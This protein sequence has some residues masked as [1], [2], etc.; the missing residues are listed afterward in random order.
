MSDRLAYR[1]AYAAM[2]LALAAACTPGEADPIPAPAAQ[3]D[4][5]AP[6]PDAAPPVANTSET[7]AS[8]PASELPAPAEPAA[9]PAAAAADLSPAPPAPTAETAPV[10][11]ALGAAAWARTCAMCHGP[12]GKGTQMAKAI[13]TRSIEVVKNKVTKG[14][15]NP[16]DK[17]PP[18]GAALSA[19]EL[20]AV[21]H[22]VAGGFKAQ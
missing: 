19:E 3:S 8:S 12:D 16:G 22:F 11:L 18:L 4:I 17:M 20:E 6:T 10:D 14:T 5:V 9:T 21:S 15:I 2:V 1:A 7:L 13:A